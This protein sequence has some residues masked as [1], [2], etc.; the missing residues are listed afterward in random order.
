[1]A[2]R[3]GNEVDLRLGRVLHGFAAIKQRR[4]RVLLVDTGSTSLHQLPLVTRIA[5]SL[6]RLIPRPFTRRSVRLPLQPKVPL[7][8]GLP[9]DLGDGERRDLTSAAAGPR[10]AKKPNRDH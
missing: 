4:V 7:Q 8:G 2:S 3:L 5:S 1:M 10:R 6:S 9:S